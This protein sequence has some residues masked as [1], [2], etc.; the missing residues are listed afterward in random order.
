MIPASTLARQQAI[1]AHW[2][3]E[4]AAAITRPDQLIA[5]LGLDAR[6]I[7]PARASGAVFRLRVPWSYVRRM[8]HGD[9]HDPLLRQVLPLAEERQELPGFVS[10]PL[11]EH[12]AVR[13]PGLLQKYRGRALLIATAACAVHCRYCF[14]REFPYSEQAGEGPRWNEAIA[15]I[16]QDPSIEEIILSG[17][18]P[19]SLSDARLRALSAELAR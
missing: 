3:Q 7:E 5:T 11:G 9:P 15:A 2:Q 10:D 14:R 12:H 6:L 4:M 17:G 8:R 19:L 16:A 1:T 13:A 18:D